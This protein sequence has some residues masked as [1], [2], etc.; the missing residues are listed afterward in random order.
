MNVGWK[1]GAGVGACCSG[2][3]G[4]RHQNIEADFHD[5]G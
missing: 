4:S 3:Y 1:E 5:L 2:K